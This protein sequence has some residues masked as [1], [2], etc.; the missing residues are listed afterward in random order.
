MASHMSRGTIYT[1][2]YREVAFYFLR[3]DFNINYLSLA[4]TVPVLLKSSSENPSTL[5]PL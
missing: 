4:I 1:L 5:G 3:N 2:L